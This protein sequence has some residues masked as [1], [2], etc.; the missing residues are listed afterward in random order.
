VAYGGG[1]LF[2]IAHG[3]GVADAFRDA[4]VPIQDAKAISTSG[5]AWIAAWKQL[6]AFLEERAD[7]LRL[8]VAE[9]RLTA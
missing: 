5:G 8:L 9:L 2:A 3:L 4:G 6:T 1:G 7:L